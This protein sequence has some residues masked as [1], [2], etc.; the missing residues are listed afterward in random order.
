MSA[1]QFPPKQTNLIVRNIKCLNIATF[2]IPRCMQYYIS[3]GTVMGQ[4]VS[5]TLG[6]EDRLNLLA[7][8]WC[9]LQT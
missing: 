2:D 9:E 1:N 6:L 5:F 4:C 8:A 7:L 3:M